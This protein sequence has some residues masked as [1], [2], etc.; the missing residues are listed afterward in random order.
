MPRPDHRSTL[1]VS[2]LVYLASVYAEELLYA[3]V[4]ALQQSVVDAPGDRLRVDLPRAPMQ[5]AP[6]EYTLVMPYA[7]ATRLLPSGP[8][9]LRASNAPHA[10]LP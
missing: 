6:R 9:P 10:I 3:L 7:E 4:P 1:I 5:D 2:V 8:W